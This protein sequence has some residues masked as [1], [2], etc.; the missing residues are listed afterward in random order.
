MKQSPF[1]MQLRRPEVWPLRALLVLALLL[2]AFAWIAEEVFE[3]DSASFDR[4][5]LLAF[6]TAGDSSNPIGPPWVEEAARDITA[7][8]STIVLGFICC[9]VGGYL[10]LS[11]QRNQAIIDHALSVNC[12]IF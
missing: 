8:G 11:K 4:A 12:L 5:I 2:L 6:R 9:A 7:L 10:L 1:S 3:G